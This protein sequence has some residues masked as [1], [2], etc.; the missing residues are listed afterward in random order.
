MAAPTNTY[1]TATAVGNR[2]DLSDVIYKTSPTDT[3]FFSLIGKGSATGVKHEWQTQALATPGDNAAPEGDDAVAVAAIPTKRL[4]NYCQI[5]TKTVSVS[6]T[7]DAVNSAGRKK[8]FGYQMMLKSQELKLDI[9][10]GLTR[11]SVAVTSGTRK[12]RGMIGWV[13]AANVNAGA[14]YVAPNYETN[15]AQTDGTLRTFAESQIKD[16]AQKCYTSGG[17]PSVIMMGPV[18]KQAFSA[19]TGGSTRFDK[20]EDKSVTAAVDVYVS[21]FGALKAIPNRV[22]RAR[23]VAVLDPDMWSVDYLRSFQT[24]D[25]AKTGDSTRKQ[26]LVEYTLACKNP[27]A[28]GFIVDVN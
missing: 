9:E 12:A 21:D 6:G 24:I 28:S 26:L 17:N 4:N 13:D 27:L 25:L 16:V 1:T 15:V 19:F 8:E 18:L 3:P 22:M 5:A 2:E 20:S 23:D 10:Y 11:N 14:G 7:Q